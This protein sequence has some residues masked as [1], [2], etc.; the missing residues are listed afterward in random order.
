MTLNR[1]GALAIA[2]A[3]LAPGLARAEYE[4]LDSFYFNAGVAGIQLQNDDLNKYYGNNSF[5]PSITESYDFAFGW[6]FRQPFAIEFGMTCGPFRS[7][8]GNYLMANANTAGNDTITDSRDEYSYSFY[9]MPALRLI[10]PGLGHLPLL[11]TFGVKLGGSSMY[12]T[13]TFT[14]E[15]TGDV[16]TQTNTGTGDY[17]A[18]VYRAE[19]MLGRSL[20]LG[21]ELGYASNVFNEVDY[22][23][24]NFNGFPGDPLDYGWT[25]VDTN[26]DG[27]NEQADFSGPYVKVMVGGWFL[28]AFRR[29][30]PGQFDTSDPDTQVVPSRPRNLRPA[31]GPDEASLEGGVFTS[32]DG[33]RLVKVLSGGDA[34]L[35][36]TATPP[37]FTPVFLAHNVARV[38]FSS[39]DQGQ[40][41]QVQL[42]LADGSTLHFDA[43]GQAI[44]F[45]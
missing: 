43:S 35:Y 45:H 2:A 19:Q 36:D 33:S 25:G 11:H 21:L 41:L 28:P 40:P 9:V 37:T 26:A 34:F 15:T 17:F 23:S 7:V 8:S 24:G 32:P 13:E 44:R 12:G 39:T 29:I 16:R 22:S 10:S 42:N 31:P 27:S 14:D 20:S 4:Q 38:R 18:V 30:R 6:Q 3:V 1:L 5:S